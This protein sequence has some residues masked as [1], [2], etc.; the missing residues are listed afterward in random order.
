MT[1]SL[2]ALPVGTVLIDKSGQHWKLRC[3]QSRDGQGILYEGTLCPQAG[4]CGAGRGWA[5][6]GWARLGAKAKGR[7]PLSESGDG[8]YPNCRPASRQL[9]LRAGTT[10]LCTCSGW[11]GRVDE[12]RMLGVRRWG[13]AGTVANQSTCALDKEDTLLH[14]HLL[15]SRGSAGPVWPEDKD[16]DDCCLSCRDRMDPSS[17]FGLNVETD[18]DTKGLLLA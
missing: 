7:E 4:R 16:S 2:K 1:T 11:E 15:L 6:L 10:N 13:V 3:L 18:E 12:C 17:K 8:A 5:G 14:C 9:S